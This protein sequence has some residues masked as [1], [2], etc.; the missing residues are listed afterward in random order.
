M[1][2]RDDDIDLCIPQVFHGVL[3]HT[4]FVATATQR[5]LRFVNGFLPK[6]TK[7]YYDTLAEYLYQSRLCKS[8]DPQQNYTNGF[9]AQ[10]LMVSPF[11]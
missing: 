9:F 5:G 4:D 7:G 11:A 6:T 8:E 1:A 3:F 2:Y 10:V